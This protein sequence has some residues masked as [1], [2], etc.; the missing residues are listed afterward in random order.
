[1]QRRALPATSKGIEEKGTKEPSEREEDFDRPL[2]QIPKQ[3][4][5]KRIQLDLRKF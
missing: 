2:V 4:E 1:M 3:T 5:T